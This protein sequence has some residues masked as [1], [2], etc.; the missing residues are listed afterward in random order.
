MTNILIILLAAVGLNFIITEGTIFAAVREWIRNHAPEW[1]AELSSCPQ[2]M[3]FWTGITIELVARKFAEASVFDQA[4]WWLAAIA[5]GLA[6]SALS[7]F[8]TGVRH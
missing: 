3:G 8:I 4:P 6:T 5:A 7:V 2:C 1:T